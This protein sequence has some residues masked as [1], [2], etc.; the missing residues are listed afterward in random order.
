MRR[1]PFA[2]R[3][4]PLR[5]SQ[6]LRR[7][8]FRRG[9]PAVKDGIARRKNRSGNLKPLGHKDLQPVFR[10]YIYER[11][12][13]VCVSCGKTCTDANRQPGHLF[14][15]SKGGMALRY[16]EYNVSV[17]CA[18]CNGPGKGESALYAKAARRKWGNEAYEAME[19]MYLEQKR[20]GGSMYKI[21]WAAAI[22]YYRDALANLRAGIV[23][24]ASLV[25]PFVR[26]L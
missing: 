18:E 6:G 16:S 25:P 7:G 8:A 13:Y 10:A 4:T 19:A 14:L 9:E 23:S 21:D 20:V 24:I 22:R 17:Q 11:D 5:A 3:K 1:T 26:R 15:S 12:G 2:P